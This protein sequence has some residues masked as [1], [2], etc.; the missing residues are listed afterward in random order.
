MILFDSWN[1]SGADVELC[2]FGALID[3]LLTPEVVQ[4]QLF[5][6]VITSFRAECSRAVR[7]AFCSSAKVQLVLDYSFCPW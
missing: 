4:D 3:A 5:R 1:Q 2:A 7:M 6:W